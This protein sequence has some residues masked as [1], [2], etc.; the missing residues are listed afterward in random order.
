EKI[1]EAVIDLL[2][3]ANTT[4]KKSGLSIPMSSSLIVPIEVPAVD[5]RQLAQIIPIE[6]R[7]YIPMPISEVSLDWLV[8][9]KEQSGISEPESEAQEEASTKGVTQKKIEKMNILL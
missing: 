1:A 9:P 7:K 5:E 2:R 8:I 3:E 4:T 6:A